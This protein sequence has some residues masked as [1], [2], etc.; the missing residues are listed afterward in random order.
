M[1]DFSMEEARKQIDEIKAELETTYVDYCERDE[2]E[3]ADTILKQDF[4]T[5]V[6]VDNLPVVDE[7][8]YPK[9]LG[10]LKK[11]YSQIGELDPDYGYT[12]PMAGGKT[13]GFAF[14]DFNTTEE[15]KKAVQN[16]NGWKLDKKHIF[17]VNLYDD[18][19]KFEEL[20]EVYKE[21]EQK[22]FQALDD[23]FS[24]L[25]DPESR[26]QYVLRFDMD[27]EIFWTKADATSQLD[28]GG[29]REKDMGKTWCELYVQWSTQGSYLATYHRQG[30]ALWGAS[31]WKKLG[32][33]AHNSVKHIEFSPKE[34]YMA[35]Y[36]DQEG[37]KAWIIW[38]LANGKPM[39]AFPRLT[40]DTEEGSPPVTSMFKWSADDKYIARLGKDVITI[41]ETP[42]MQ[43]LEK[44]SLKA[45]A[46]RDFQWSPACDD[47]GPKLVYWAPERGNAP[48]CVSLLE[49]P[50]RN[51]L[52]TKNLVNVNNCKLH[53]HP[54]GK[55]LCVKVV[56]HTKSKKTMYTNFEIFRACE[57]QVAVEGLEMKE[58]VVAFAWEPK[59]D[60][61]GIIH[62]DGNLKLNVSFYTMAGGKGRDELELIRKLEGKPV[63]NLFWSPQGNHLVIAGLGDNFTGNVEFWNVDEDHMY[64]EKEHFK[65]NEI[66]WDPSGRMVTTITGQPLEGAYYKYT[67]DNGFTVW[68]FQ[69]KRLMQEKKEKF[70]QF[71]WR[72]RPVSGLSVK[73]QKKIVKNLKKYQEK[74][75]E[76]DQKKKRAAHEERLNEQRSI[77]KAFKDAVAAAKVHWE[78]NYLPIITDLQGG[79]D[80]PSKY[81]VTEQTVETVISAEEEIMK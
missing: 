7:A 48:A 55:Y 2:D 18:L 70:Y 79:P 78:Q 33:F 32:R 57:K 1:S 28:Y 16:T 80:D 49:L 40:I 21:P 30:I 51:V 65:C 43:L 69:G 54:D 14:L 35:T 71:S 47:S 50:S 29:E 59:G 42:S 26:D 45:P 63:N 38:N 53:W 77:R 74:Y 62:G 41:Y 5:C 3:D 52:R 25:S 27:T 31:D 19:Q 73:E 64:A 6:V 9:L 81:R 11:I 72:P 4:R 60:R 39:R 37:D 22:D 13:L 17:R 68:S 44:R 46:V 67:M 23:P 12:M 76:Y 61:F 56:R 24:W 66:Q 20:P 58:T 10:V 15:A 34:N 8:K 75:Q 36:N